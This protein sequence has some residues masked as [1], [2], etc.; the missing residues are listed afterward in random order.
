VFLWF[1]GHAD[2]GGF[3]FENIPGF[4][5]DIK[6][7]PGH[8]FFDDSLT[9]VADPCKANPVSIVIFGYYVEKLYSACPTLYAVT[10]HDVPPSFLLSEQELKG[11]AE[12]LSYCFMV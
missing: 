12:D 8:G 11:L 6:K 2:R 1:L 4:D 9:P 5:T 7:M 10:L 3:H